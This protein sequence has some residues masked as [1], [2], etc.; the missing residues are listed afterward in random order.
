MLHKD[1]S[2]Y[3]KNGRS[4]SCPRNLFIEL[5]EKIKE[6]IKDFSILHSI[7]QRYTKYL[8]PVEMYILGK[9]EEWLIYV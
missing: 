7:L 1:V 9:L 6:K 8:A 3:R 2:N 5:I 4:H